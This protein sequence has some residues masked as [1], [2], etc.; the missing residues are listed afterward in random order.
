MAESASTALVPRAEKVVDF[1]G[2]GITVALVDDEVYV[3]LRPL[4]EFLGLRWGSQW[5]RV[6]RD[7][8]LARYVRQVRMT[9]ADGRQR[10]LSC[11]PLEYLPGWLFGITTSRVR[12]DLQDKLRR[13]REECFRVLWQAFQADVVQT[14]PAAST[15]GSSLSQVRDL[16]LAIAQMAE[17]QLALEGRVT[18]LAQQQ[19]SMQGH[20]V[21]VA[22]RMDRA[23]AVV[24]EL[25][26]RL[27][28]VEQQVDPRNYISHAQATELS[29]HVK[30]LATL[31]TEHGTK[32]NHY[33]GVFAELYRRF[34]VS[35]Y[36][37]VTRE[38]YT[39]VLAFLEEW[40]QAVL[41][42]TLEPPV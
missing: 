2:D 20:I 14:V 7:E 32:D 41:G 24:G 23:A 26:R 40:R 31:M 10:D 30:A 11:I 38:Q 18:D 19:T 29:A 42:G 35:S 15:P 9:G 28:V 27:D 3:P 1:Y 13:Y 34:G 22:T 12:A 21:T 36:K 5:S 4:T 25:Q 17:Q 6:Q 8:V 33:Q 39:A 16:A 37:T